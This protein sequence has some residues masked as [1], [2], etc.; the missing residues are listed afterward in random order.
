MA[1][2]RTPGGCGNGKGAEG[3]GRGVAGGGGSGDV[4][5]SKYGAGVERRDEQRRVG[6]EWGRRWLTMVMRLSTSWYAW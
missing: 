6:R 4:R 3:R 2:K 5:W 1:G